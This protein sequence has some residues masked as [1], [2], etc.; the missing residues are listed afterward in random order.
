[1][2]FFGHFE[3]AGLCSHLLLG[4]I[5]HVARACGW[6][7]DGRGAILVLPDTKGEEV[8]KDKAT[9]PKMNTRP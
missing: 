9:C 5:A 8:K 7:R 6:I 1:M 2:L 4:G 3:S